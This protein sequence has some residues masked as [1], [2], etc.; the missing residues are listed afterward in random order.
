MSANANVIRDIFIHFMQ[1]AFSAVRLVHV[2]FISHFSFERMKNRYNLK[3]Q[4]N[5]LKTV[6][7]AHMSVFLFAENI[8]CHCISEKVSCQVLACRG[9][10]MV[11]VVNVS[12]S[13]TTFYK[14][15]SNAI[16]GAEPE[17]FYF[18]EHLKIVFVLSLNF[19]R[20]IE[21]F[22]NKNRL[23]LIADCLCMCTQNFLQFPVWNTLIVDANWL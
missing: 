15:F 6:F 10:C 3:N 19:Q 21:C 13:R 2:T 17:M 7:F 9:R 14:S 16:V 22:H 20:I 12:G 4:F 23:T 1:G 8:L 18:P 11:V 5:F